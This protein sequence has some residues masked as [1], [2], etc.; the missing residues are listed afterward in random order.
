MLK[1]MAA[2]VLEPAPAPAHNPA[3]VVSDLSAF[4][5]NML[6]RN[7]GS[8]AAPPNPPPIQTQSRPATQAP[9]P[10]K[11]KPQ[12]PQSQSPNPPS[13]SRR[14][15]PKQETRSSSSCY[16]AARKLAFSTRIVLTG[17]A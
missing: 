7:A 4:V 2:P 15:C 17:I 1:L 9:K 12:T 3:D 8:V 11:P 13:L 6:G 10:P 14:Q 5:L 16:S